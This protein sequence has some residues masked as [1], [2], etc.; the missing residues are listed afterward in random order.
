MKLYV[1]HVEVSLLFVNDDASMRSGE[2]LVS[3][4]H[5]ASITSCHLRTRESI[6]NNDAAESKSR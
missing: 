6:R 1:S 5:A 4:R 2:L 3:S